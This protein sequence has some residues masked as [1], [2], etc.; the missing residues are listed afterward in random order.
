[1]PRVLVLGAGM[2]AR[3]LVQ[4]LLHHGFEVTVTSRNPAHSQAV[5]GG[6]PSARALILYVDDEEAVRREV[7]AHDA[8][9][10]MLPWTY[11][12]GV[13]RICLK[14]GRH[15]VTTS[16]VSEEMKA[17]GPD[18]EQ[19]GLL[20]LNEIGLD[21]GI[22]HMATMQM[23]DRLREDSRELLHYRSYTGG[24][25]APDSRTTPWGYKFSWSPRGVLLA[26]RNSARWLEDGEAVEVVPEDLFT[27]TWDLRVGEYDLEAYPNR[28]SL[29]Y[30]DRYGLQGIR[31]LFRG[32]LRYPGWCRTMK[33]VV[34]LGLLDLEE[35]DLEGMSYRDL[36]ADLA[37]SDRQG[38]V[39]SAVADRVGFS[40]QDDPIERLRWLGL[41]EPEP[42]PLERAAPLDVLTDLM[43]RRLVYAEGERDLIV[44]YHRFGLADGAEITSTLI[45]RGHPDGDSAM[46][47]TV[48]L[49]AAIATRLLLKDGISVRGV[50]IP[51]R[52]EIYE[53]VLSELERLD[54]RF[55]HSGG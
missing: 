36:M 1:M 12:L 44:Q 31:T 17:L 11:H 49:P 15:L 34:D 4:Y 21:P 24:L 40:P 28:D 46:A 32:T 19:A 13:A 9:L 37:G 16:Y 55:E 6:H 43:N 29:E 33:A 53:P 20:F 3:P 7:V 23:V 45:D 38:D 18:V 26:G 14:E 54:I 50:R 2:V 5:A 30:V 8:V 52:R 27:H 10:S 42:I 35:R 47:R 48:G 51:N 39:D 22:D 25:P 41:F